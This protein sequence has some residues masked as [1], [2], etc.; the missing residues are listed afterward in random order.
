M[1]K[2]VERAS[3][4]AWCPST[5]Y[6]SYI[7]SGTIAGTID[8]SFETKSQLEIYDASLQ[9]DGYD[10]KMLG[11]VVSKDCFHS[12]AWGTKG[13]A[14][15]QFSHGLVAGGMSDG[16]INIWDVN[17]IINK[18]QSLLARAELH[19][20][21]V[22]GLDFHPKQ[23]NLL[24]SGSTDGEVYIW[25]LV[26]PAQPSAS[27]PQSTP[28]VGQSPAVTCLAWNKKVA[29]IIASSSET[30]KSTATCILVIDCFL[31]ILGRVRCWK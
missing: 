19:R 5:K 11:S 14:E 16:A 28:K 21:Q 18:E 23:A 12:I 7:A 24:A 3:R 8:D 15:G 4:V 17:S 13:I 22:L 1:L 31:N 26:N 6:A 27:K 2:Q 30:G 25:D 10:M 29:Q 9:R 20:G